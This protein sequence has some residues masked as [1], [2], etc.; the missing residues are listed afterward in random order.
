VDGSAPEE[1]AE[2]RYA[3]AEE[4]FLNG[5]R[6]GVDAESL[7]RLASEV[8]ERSAEWN[9]VAYDALHAAGSPEDRMALD[10]RTERT[11]MLAGLWTDMARAFQG[12]PAL[13]DG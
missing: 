9:R 8:A 3:M 4:A 13:R 11:E 6:D 5:V 1:A 7:T 10:L 2:R 12:L